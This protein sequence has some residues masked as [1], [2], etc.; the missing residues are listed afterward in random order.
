[1]ADAPVAS[2]LLFLG[3]QPM[4]FGETLLLPARLRRIPL[5]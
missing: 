3:S 4:S 2:Q 1:M 5:A